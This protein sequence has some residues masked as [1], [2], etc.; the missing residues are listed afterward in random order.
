[1]PTAGLEILTNTAPLQFFLQEISLNTLTR[2]KHINFQ[3]E[4]ARQIHLNRLLTERQNPN[5]TSTIRSDSQSRAEVL[6]KEDLQQPGQ[7]NLTEGN[8]NILSDGS[9]EDG[10]Y[11]SGF[12]IKL[13]NQTWVGAATGGSHFSVFLSELF[14]HT[15]NF[16]LK[17]NNWSGPV[18]I[19]SDSLS[20][21]Q[22]IQSVSSSSRGVQKC[23][24]RRTRQDN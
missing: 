11:G 10:C 24:P 3:F 7:P 20:A 14:C 17:E 4:L 1:M 21:I 6:S 13:S 9:G 8:V 19:F 18:N 5:G 2:S 12:L 22:A 15:G 16:L 23:G